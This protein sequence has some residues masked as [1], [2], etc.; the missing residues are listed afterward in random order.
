MM[1]Q[2]ETITPV[3]TLE[4]TQ[5]S[6]YVR[7]VLICSGLGILFLFVVARLLVPNPEGI[8]THRQLGLPPCS[9][10][11][12]WGI[13][14]PSCGM[15]TSWSWMLRGQW[16]LAAQ[17]NA[18]GLWLGIWCGLMTPWFIGSGLK[19]KW[20]W[21]QPNVYFGAVFGGTTVAIMFVVWMLKLFT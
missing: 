17:T 15:T 1:N 8:G 5:F 3:P 9:F 7:V 18:A 20:I 16:I 10:Y 11:V 2:S 13:P 21:F 14:C 6:S 12:F 4:P 19:G